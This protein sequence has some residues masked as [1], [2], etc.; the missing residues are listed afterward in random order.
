MPDTGLPFGLTN[1]GTGTVHVWVMGSTTLSLSAIARCLHAHRYIRSAAIEER[2]EG[3]VV[4]VKFN[5]DF[6]DDQY[7]AFVAHMIR[8][9]MP[10]ER[11]QQRRFSLRGR[12]R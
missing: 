6:D 11:P 4:I 1:V 8:Q 10:P 12:R 3:E 5:Y 9:L 2:R 7:I